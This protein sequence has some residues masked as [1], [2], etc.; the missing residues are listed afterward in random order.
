MPEPVVHRR[1][2]VCDGAGMNSSADFSNP[3]TAP[4]PL[5]DVISLWL[6]FTHQHDLTHSIVSHLCQAKDAHPLTEAQQL[7]VATMAHSCLRPRCKDPDCLKIAAG[8]PFRL[9]LLQAFAARAKDPDH[10]RPP[11]SPLPRQLDTSGAKPSIAPPTPA[12]GSGQRLGSA[13]PRQRRRRGTP[14]ASRH[15][16]WQA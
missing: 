6:Q 14:L 11:P 4:S 13:F 15:R 5:Q 16:H 1:P 3:S 12:K 8:Q 2:L 7:E 10:R 9:K